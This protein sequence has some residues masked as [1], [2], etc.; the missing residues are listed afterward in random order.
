MQDE[1]HLCA[2]VGLAALA[3][4]DAVQHRA[5]HAQLALAQVVDVLVHGALGDQAVHLRK[6]GGQGRSE[7]QREETGMRLEAQQT[8]GLN[9][10]L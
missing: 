7:V 4:G 1:A 10:V 8:T 3:G 5:V 2:F 9:Q 6:R